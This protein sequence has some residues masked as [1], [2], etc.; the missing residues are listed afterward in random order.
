MTWKEARLTAINYIR[1]IGMPRRVDG[2]RVLLTEYPDAETLH[3][4]RPDDT[5]DGQRLISQAFAR[6]VRKRG[7][8]VEF[9]PITLSGYFDWLTEFRLPETPGNRAQ[10]IAWITTPEPRP[11]PIGEVGR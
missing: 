3:F 5:L 1:R 6:E 11:A 2:L 9:I 8:T 4:L 7:G 10:Y